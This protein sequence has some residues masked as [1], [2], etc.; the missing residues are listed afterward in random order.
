MN[1]EKKNTNEEI[2]EKIDELVEEQKDYLEDLQRLQAEFENFQKRTEIEKS[3]LIKSANKNLILEFLPILDNLEKAIKHEPENKAIEILNKSIFDI[4]EKQ[5]LKEIPT[6]I[7]FNPKLHEAIQ[8]EESDSEN[9][10][11]E[12]YTKGYTLNEKL[13]KPAIVKISKL[14][15]TNNKEQNE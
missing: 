14:K 1:E 11:L 7:L 10:I 13:L 9:D 8:T 5:G 6:N 2:E 4:L 3:E 15:E 12:V